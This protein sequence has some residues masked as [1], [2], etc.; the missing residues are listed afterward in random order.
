[1]NRLIVPFLILCSC[2]S[3]IHGQKY[4]PRTENIK[5][6][7]T[8]NHV[9][10]NY[11]ITGSGYGQVHDIDFYVIDN[12]GNLVFPDSLSGDIGTGIEP[13][14]FKRIIWEIYKEF[15]VVYGNFEPHIILD[16][17]EN[18]GIKGGPEYALLSV[19]V[20]GLGDYFVADHKNM[21]IKP[22]YKTAF[23]FG[24]LSLSLTAHLNREYIP[25]VMGEPGWYW[26]TFPVGDGHY[27]G[28]Y[29]YKDVW[30]KDVERT[31][32]WLFRYDTEIFL[33]IGLTAMLID[34]IWVARQGVKNNKLRN[35][36][37][38]KLSLN[39]THQGLSLGY[40]HVF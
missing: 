5:L 32:Y 7:F 12:I 2:N 38:D 25:P 15:D 19:L 20:P 37:L 3:F 10:I 21:K 30:I 6:N 9:E 34:V 35:E 26:H 16:G 33:G 18:F 22:Y 40:T 14:S 31:E 13:G 17:H 39:S 24:F 29:L 1:M 8:E 27:D 11:D 4:R 36:F 28:I 23:I